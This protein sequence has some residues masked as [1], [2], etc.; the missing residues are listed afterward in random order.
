MI[1][2]AVDPSQ[3]GA[4]LLV[5]PV[6]EVEPKTVDPGGDELAEHRLGGGGRADRRQDLGPPHRGGQC[7]RVK[8]PRPREPRGSRGGR[9]Y[10]ARRLPSAQPRGVVAKHAGLWSRRQR[11]ESA[12]GY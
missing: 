10:V 1:D 3:D 8:E 4:V 11:F 5:R 6:G 12:R 7:L 9:P 2:D